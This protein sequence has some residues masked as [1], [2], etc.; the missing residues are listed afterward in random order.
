MLS[1]KLLEMLINWSNEIIDFSK[2]DDVIS[3]V[4]G[5]LTT[6]L[7]YIKG[8]FFVLPF[9]VT[10]ACLGVVVAVLVVRVVLAVVNVVWP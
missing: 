1:L 2:L 8:A 9:G 3:Q 10:M 4:S 6:L 5:A 7:S